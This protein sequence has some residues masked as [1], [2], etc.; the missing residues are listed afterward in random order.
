[1]VDDSVILLSSLHHDYTIVD[2][3]KKKPE[4]ILYYNDTKGG[5][6]RMDQIVQTY[7]CKRK[8]KRWPMTLF[9]N[10]IDVGTIAAFVVW[11]TKNVHWNERKCHR[12]RLFLME[13]GYDL[14]QSHLDRRVHLPEA[15]QKNVRLALQAIGI[16]VTTSQSNTVLEVTVKKLCQVCPRERDRKVITHCASCDVP[17]CPDHHKVICTT[18]SETFLR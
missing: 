9:F 14:L 3:E 2:E 16:T 11:T 4:I 10:I 12:R 13:L 5:V 15:L 6:D 8:T 1:M 18:C 7:S 17:C